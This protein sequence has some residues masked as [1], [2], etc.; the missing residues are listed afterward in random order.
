MTDAIF[1]AASASRAR[2]PLRSGA[3]PAA[4]AEPQH[5]IAMYGEP[6]LPPDFVSLPYANPDAPK[7]GRIVVRR[8]GQLRFAQ[9][10]HPQGQRPRRGCR[11]LTVE[12]LM[13]RTYDEPFTLY[14][15]LAESVETD[16][17]PQLRRIHPARGGPILRRQPGHGR[18]RALVLRDTRHHR[19]PAL[20][21]RLGE[22]R[23]VPRPSAPRTVRFTFNTEDRELPPDPGPAPDPE[24]GAVGG[25]GLRGSRRWTPPSAP[26][27]TWSTAFE[28]G[29]SSP[30]A[31]TRTGGGR[32][33]PST[34][35]SRISTRSATTIFADGGVV[36]EAFKAGDITAY[37]EA[38]PAEMGQQLRL[39]RRAV[40]RHRQARDPAPAPLGDRSG[41]VM[42]TRE[43]PLRGLARARGD[44]RGLQLRVHQPDR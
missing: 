6:A 35:A 25:E 38:N 24:E 2:W 22:D 3:R 40:G 27:P 5:G 15:L 30:I 12:T 13:G 39:P 16:D 17:G 34:A 21:R 26:A 20:P 33:C 4:A 28:P 41:F 32:T 29:A 7:G 43:T 14:G 23:Q 37:R 19:Q 31:A 36:F 10:L 8:V 1:P 18:G 42:N 9:S 11:A 44:D